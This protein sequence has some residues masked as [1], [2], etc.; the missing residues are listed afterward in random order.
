MIERRRRGHDNG[1]LSLFSGGKLT[2]TFSFSLSFSHSHVNCR[3]RRQIA[4][5]QRA[6]ALHGGMANDGLSGRACVSL[7]ITISTFHK[8]ISLECIIE[9]VM[10]EWHKSGQL[11]IIVPLR[12]WIDQERIDLAENPGVTWSPASICALI[13]PSLL[14]LLL[15]RSCGVAPP[16]FSPT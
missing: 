6:N 4:S 13:A 2:F 15:L 7:S 8:S 12:S 11:I 1:F 14:L 10:I 5:A 3:S 9:W 16:H